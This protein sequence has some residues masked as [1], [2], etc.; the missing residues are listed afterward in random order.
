MFFNVV[1]RYERDYKTLV[2][3]NKA[4]VSDRYDFLAGD[5]ALLRALDRIFDGARST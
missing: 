1:A 3:T 5:N 4:P 2:L